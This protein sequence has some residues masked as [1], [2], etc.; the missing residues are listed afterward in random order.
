MGV[1]SDEVLIVKIAGLPTWESW[2]RHHL[3]VTFMVCHKKYYKG[4]GGGF[5]QVWGMMSF[6]NPCMPTAS[7]MHQKCCNYALTNL[8]FD[9]CRSLRMIDLL[10]IHPSPHP[11]SLACP[12]YPQNALNQGPY[13]NSFFLHCFHFGIYILVFQRIWGCAIQT[14]F[15]LTTQYT[16]YN[17][18]KKLKLKISCEI[19]FFQISFYKGF[20]NC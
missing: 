20:F 15:P 16:C 12:S 14:L 11:E 9:L 19:L 4:E 8:L 10:V 6:L 13:C 7:S 3:D 1:E 17:I 5:P 2:K 18:S